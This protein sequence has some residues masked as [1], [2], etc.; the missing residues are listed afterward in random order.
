MYSTSFSNSGGNSLTLVTEIL[1]V[2]ELDLDGW[3]ESVAVI[4]KV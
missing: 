2:P 4:V 3:P 1:K